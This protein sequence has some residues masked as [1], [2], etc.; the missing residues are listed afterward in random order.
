MLRACSCLGGLPP[1]CTP[2]LGCLVSKRAK[3]LGWQRRRV[4]GSMVGHKVP[5][6]GNKTDLGF[7]PGL[8][9]LSWETLGK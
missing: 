2:G 3:S 7:C 4:L 1:P 9:L 8:E 6:A 5:Q